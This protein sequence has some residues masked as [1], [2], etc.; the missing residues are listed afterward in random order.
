MTF[1]AFAPLLIG[2]LLAAWTLLAARAILRARQREKK[3]D[4]AQRN[5]RR[6]T[7]LVDESPAV[8]LLVRVDGRIEAPQR[9]AGWLGLDSVPRF[10]TELDGSRIDG[11]GGGIPAQQLAELAEAVKRTQRSAAPFRMVV[12]PVGGKTSLALRGHLADPQ[13]SSVARRWSGCLTSAR[14]RENWASCGR[15]PSARAAISVRWLG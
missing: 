8:P 6:L 13:V 10:L 5:A 14:P 4:A 11:A 12:T 7:R 9:L 3:A 1:S 15:K 2:L